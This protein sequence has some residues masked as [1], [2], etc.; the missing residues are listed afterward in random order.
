VADRVLSGRYRLERHLARGGMGEVYLAHDELLN[1]TVAVKELFPELAQDA[2]FVERFRREAQAAAALNHP[3]VVSVYDFGDADG[4]YFIVMEYVD[5]QTL[6]DIIREEG[7]MAPAEAVDIAAE[8][9][10]ALAAAHEQGLVHRDVKPPNVLI[11]KAD[12]TV[13][14]ADFGIARATN[15][16]DALTMPGQVVGTATYLSPEQAQGH[17][18]DHRSDLYSLG[19]VLYEMVAGRP[20][21]EAETPVAIAYKQVTETP[22]PPSTFNSRVPPKLDALV[23]KAMAKDPAARQQSA[24][25]MRAE[26]LALRAAPPAP[27]PPDPDA[28]QALPGMAAADVGA[29]EVIAAPG[30]DRT[31]VLPPPVADR[32]P[33]TGTRSTAAGAWPFSAWSSCSFSAGWS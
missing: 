1:R 21:F 24:D 8:I 6:R 18:V 16:L 3:N 10:A 31:S 15:T 12:G 23:A 19:M 28:T 17:A 22:P 13:K 9:A 7:Q 33:P 5:G 32:G 26:L 2:A 14:V 20:P 27:A 29:T 30:G 25:Q 11:T 4:V